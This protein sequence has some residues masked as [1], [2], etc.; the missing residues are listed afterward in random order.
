MATV[1]AVLAAV[2]IVFLAP[3]TRRALASP[4]SPTRRVYRAMGPE[5]AVIGIGTALGATGVGL[6]LTFVADVMMWS[7][8]VAAAPEEAPATSFWLDLLG[9]VLLV[10][11]FAVI[12]PGLQLANL[13]VEGKYRL[14]TSPWPLRAVHIVGVLSYMV[15]LGA[16]LAFAI[17]YAIANHLLV[18]IVLR[19]MLVG[20]DPWLV[21]SEAVA[22]RAS[23]PEGVTVDWPL[24]RLYLR[25]GRNAT[26][27]LAAARIWDQ[28]PMHGQRAVLVAT[29]TQV[30]FF[31]AILSPLVAAPLLRLIP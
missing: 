8:P 18:A 29:A 4:T 26:V 2:F 20:F 6:L 1:L 25:R 21:A 31:W 7:W 3:A 27:R 14:P 5:T 12:V 15:I 13:T 28:L 16:P 11:L 22:V 17:T 24:A 23:V 30:V 10:E 19:R 9:T